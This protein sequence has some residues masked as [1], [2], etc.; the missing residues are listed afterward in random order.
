MEGVRQ[1]LA[2][3]AGQAAATGNALRSAWIGA[4]GALGAAQAFAGFQNAQKQLEG[5]RQEW[6]Y[7]GLTSEQIAFNEAEFLDG[8]NDKIQGQVK[9]I[10]DAT[11]AQSAYGSSVGKTAS[12]YDD[13]ASSVSSAVSG[14]LQQSLA[15]DVA[16]P[17]K[18]KGAGGDAINENAK[19]LAAIANEGLIN[20]PWLDEFAQEA[21]QTYADLMK[22]IAEGADA[23]SAA[24]QMMAEFQ[25]GLRPDLLD[26]GMLKDQVKQQILGQQALA[27]MSDQLT[28]EIVAELGVSAQQA[29]QAIAGVVG[30]MPGG[31]A[32][33]Q[34]LGGTDLTGAG[35]SAGGSFA[36]GFAAS[37]DGAAIAVTIT[38]QMAAKLSLFEENGKTSGTKWSAG[39]YASVE[40]GLAP[41]LLA[42]LVTLVTPG[43]LA[44]IQVG[45]SQTGTTDGGQ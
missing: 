18:D 19:R 1:K 36:A 24:Q 29:Q 42:L 37:A 44:Q 4:A 25:A 41:E 26:F 33:A 17:G 13:L 14:L 32:L 6:N 23:R 7:M 35:S 10:E 31:Q 12:A 8:N 27:G 20:Q 2:E 40:S 3:L 11:K 22:K 39:F 21:P 28:K 45:A 38:A 30:N 5:L 34:D 16:W 43:V 15:L 9:L